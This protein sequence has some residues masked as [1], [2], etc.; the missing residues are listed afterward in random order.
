MCYLFS[1]DHN[2]AF[3]SMASKDTEVPYINASNIQAYSAQSYFI[4]T[5][6]PIPQNVELF[7][8]CII[9]NA[10]EC[11]VMIDDVCLKFL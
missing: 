4:V 3:V 5:Q 9:D 11:V 6:N 10:I 7:W 2:I 1:D 8:R